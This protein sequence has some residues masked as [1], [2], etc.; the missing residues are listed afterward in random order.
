LPHYGDVTIDGMPAGQ[1]EGQNKNQL[2]QGKCQSTG[3]EKRNHGKAGSHDTD[4]PRRNAGQDGNQPRKDDTQDRPHQKR[5][6]AKM[7]A[8][9]EEMKA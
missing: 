8:W 5:M 4:Q 2:S 3:N 1:N 7:D 9:L 6:E